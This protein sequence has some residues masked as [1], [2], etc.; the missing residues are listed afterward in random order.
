MK[1]SG[2]Y[3][4]YCYF[5]HGY[6]GNART[7]AAEFLSPPP[8]D[9]TDPRNLDPAGM[10]ETI[11]NGSANTAMKPFRDILSEDEIKAVARYAYDAFALCASVPA[12]Y[13]TVENGWENHRERYE[14]AYPFVLGEISPERSEPSLSEEE[15]RGRALYRQACVICHERDRTRRSGERPGDDGHDHATAS[16][17]PVAMPGAIAAV[18]GPVSGA[19]TQGAEAAQN[20]EGYG[21]GLGDGP[22]D[23]PRTIPNLTPFEDKGEHL[24]LDNCAYCHAADGTGL[25]WIGSFLEPHPPDFTDPEATAEFTDD[26]MRDAILDGVPQT[27]MPAFRQ[28]MTDEEV[29]AIIAYMNRAFLGRGIHDD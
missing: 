10:I 12:G 17:A 26:S 29:S 5:C 24:Y 6:Q 4:R 19:G 16:S 23:Q 14:A 2:I 25:N 8:R 21:Y 9:F 1:G 11:R 22:H 15:R 7:V 18:A 27:S 28:V 3:N 20:A 13:H